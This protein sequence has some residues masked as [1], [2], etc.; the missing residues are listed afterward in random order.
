MLADAALRRADEAVAAAFGE[1]SLE[2]AV[3]SAWAFVHGLANLLLDAQISDALRKG[4]SD[5]ELARA[6]IAAMAHALGGLR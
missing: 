3:L 2:D 5:Q 6:A 1:E 4:R